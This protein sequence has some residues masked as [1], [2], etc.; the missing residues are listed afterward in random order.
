MSV[1]GINDQNLISLKNI[2]TKVRYAG[3]LR[4]QEM[5]TKDFNRIPLTLLVLSQKKIPFFMKSFLGYVGD[6]LSFRLS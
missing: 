3:H 4:I 1:S 2:K 6:T 5:I